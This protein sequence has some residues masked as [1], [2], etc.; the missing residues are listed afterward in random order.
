MSVSRKL[1][2]TV[3]ATGPRGVAE[4]RQVPAARRRTESDGRGQARCMP[5]S[6]AGQPR[7]T[8]RLALSAGVAVLG[9]A[10]APGLASATNR[11]VSG[12]DGADGG[13]CQ[14]TTCK[15]VSYAVAQSQPNDRILISPG[16]YAEQVTVNGGRQLIAD[17]APR[18]TIDGGAGTAV[19]ITGGNVR[20][21]GLR[22][23]GNTHAVTVNAPAG[24]TVITGSTFDDTTANPDGQIDITAGQ[25]YIRD[26]VFVGPT[27]ASSESRALI[28]GAA[29][30][31]D[32][33]GNTFD[34]FVVSISAAGG[35]ALIRDNEITGVHAAPNLPGGGLLIGTKATV[36]GNTIAGDAADTDMS[37]GM[38]IVDEFGAFDVRTERNRVFRMSGPA[39]YTVA[40]KPGSSLVATGDV[41][42][43]NLGG[44]WIHGFTAKVRGATLWDN[45]V[46]VQ[47]MDATGGLELDSSVVGASGITA[48][49]GTCTIRFSRGPSTTGSS[50]QQFQTSADPGFTGPG[51]YRLAAGSPL[52]DAGDPTAS[53]AGETDVNG[54]ARAVVGLAT[55]G[56][57]APRRD[58]GAYE[59]V[60]A[61]PLPCVPV[62]EIVP[63]SAGTV[64]APQK[65]AVP[66]PPADPTGALTVVDDAGAPL[67]LTVDG[68]SAPQVGTRTAGAARKLAV[69][70]HTVRVAR[71]TGKALTTK[72]VVKPGHLTV[73]IV[74][75][76]GGRLKART[77]QI[78]PGA[79]KVLSLVLVPVHAG[80]TVFHYR[81][82]TTAK[83][84]SV[85]AGA[86][87]VALKRGAQLTVLVRRGAKTV[88][89]T[90][91]AS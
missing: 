69:G 66:V 10:V 85:R 11:Y 63:A 43:G 77:A 6:L 41:L 34:G 4:N 80:R 14:L 88:A 59:F 25:T 42:T 91:S 27:S 30:P 53:A 57:A 28:A 72:A 83:V 20:V 24:P 29:D 79:R 48:N 33:T 62:P 13:T 55:G 64:A 82:L 75:R 51:D 46:D 40:A 71:R 50:C 2:N 45:K 19:A 58:I 5:S 86:D 32:V 9:L 22:L 81:T 8:A 70:T 89:I 17:G 60:P 74:S 65:R 35:T 18:A 3:T 44:M 68:K 78:A 67:A 52:I 56:C 38:M 47:L 73:V 39:I 37:L 16:T 12:A 49:G 21:E 61:A 31:V 87:T 7:H 84:P 1:A 36:E 54:T 26:N 23:R 15:T 90:R 76:K